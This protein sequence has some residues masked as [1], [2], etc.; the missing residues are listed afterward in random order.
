MF[1]LGRSKAIVSL[2]VGVP[3]IR[4][5]ACS[6]GVLKTSR[7]GDDAEFISVAGEIVALSISVSAA[8]STPSMVSVPIAGAPGLKVSRALPAAGSGHSAYG[9]GLCELWPSRTT[10]AFG[11]ASTL[12]MWSQ[13]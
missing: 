12:F 3:L 11:S 5:G 10:H 8:W 4:T 7:F 13:R 1:A 9:V 2:I 6:T